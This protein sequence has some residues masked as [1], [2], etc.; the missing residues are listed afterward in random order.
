MDHGGFLARPDGGFEVDYDNVKQAVR[1]LAHDL[2]TME[3]Q[4]DY[5]AAR[6]LAQYGVMRPE[7]TR[8]LARVEHIPVDI[9]PVFI[10]ADELTRTVQ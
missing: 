8:A 2:L 10:T 6:K 7:I 9:H 5:A 3:A 1:E 4:G